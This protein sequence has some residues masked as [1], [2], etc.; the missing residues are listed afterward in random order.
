MM[1]GKDLVIIRADGTTYEE[2][3]D[4]FQYFHPVFIK[5]FEI[6]QT[7]YLCRNRGGDFALN[8]NTRFMAAVPLSLRN[9]K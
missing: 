2:N 6:Y 9:H 3:L 7:L 4:F 5:D 8:A 1:K